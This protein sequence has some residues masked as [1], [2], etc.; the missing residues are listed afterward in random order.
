[1]L[2]MAA[3]PGN[4]RDQAYYHKAVAAAKYVRRGRRHLD[5]V[6]IKNRELGRPSWRTIPGARDYRRREVGAMRR[7]IR[8]AKHR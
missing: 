7:G 6:K 4:E 3:S 1:M 5:G 2:G 8:L